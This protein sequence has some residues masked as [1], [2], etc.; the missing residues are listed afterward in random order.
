M[1]EDSNPQPDN[2]FFASVNEYL[3]LTRK[4]STES[5]PQR[6]S[7]AS[8]FAGDMFLP[9]VLTMISFFRSMSRT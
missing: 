5:G 4:Q 9:P 6:P 1:A 7:V 3:D 8:M 2:A